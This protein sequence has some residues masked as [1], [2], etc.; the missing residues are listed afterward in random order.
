MPITTRKYT[1]FDLSFQ[2]HPVTGDIT[3]KVDVASIMQSLRSLFATS[4]YERLFR[5]NIGCNLKRVLFDPIDAGSTTKIK[6]EVELTIRNFEPRVDLQTVEVIPNYDDHRY[7]VQI[8][9][10]IVNNPNPITVNFFL[11]RVR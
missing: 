2:K 8:V 4:F 1:D 6:N 7:D 3:K 5:P 11:E 10:Y 9:F